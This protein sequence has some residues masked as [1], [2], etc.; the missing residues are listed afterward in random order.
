MESL[1][2]R[3][4]NVQIG[5]TYKRVKFIEE[6]E[7]AKQGARSIPACR[8]NVHGNRPYKPFRNGID[9]DEWLKEH[10]EYD[11]PSDLSEENDPR[12]VNRSHLHYLVE[13]L[14]CAFKRQS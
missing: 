1:T 7:E 5:Q 8:L 13:L 3:L 11:I 14:E 12:T 2:N 10:G 6:D 4:E 9:Y